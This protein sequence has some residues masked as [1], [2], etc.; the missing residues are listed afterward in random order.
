MTV[1]TIRRTVF[2]GGIPGRPNREERFLNAAFREFDEHGEFSSR[3]DLKRH[4]MQTG[5]VEFYKSWP[6]LSSRFVRMADGQVELSVEGLAQ[7]AGAERFLSQFIDVLH[8]AVEQYQE[9]DSKPLISV[10]RLVA[11]VPGVSERR[12]RGLMRM[13]E[14]EGLL[15][16]SSPKAGSGMLTAKLTRLAGVTDVPQYLRKARGFT[17]WRR[18]RQGKAF[19]RRLLTRVIGP[20]SSFWAKL[21]AGIVMT[22]LGLLIGNSGGLLP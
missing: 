14:R 18:L 1:A 9:K 22:A 5:A 10:G 3:D 13:L 17:R 19:L 16:R 11:E 20:D 7:V 4:F 12:A 21:A 15:R 6:R 8:I 2:W